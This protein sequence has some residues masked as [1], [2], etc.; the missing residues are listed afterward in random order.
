MRTGNPCGPDSV[1]CFHTF[2]WNVFALDT[3]YSFGSPWRSNKLYRNMDEDDSDDGFGPRS[4]VSFGGSS[5]CTVVNVEPVSVVSD[6]INSNLDQ[7]IREAQYRHCRRSFA[8]ANFLQGSAVRMPWEGASGM[9]LLNEMITNRLL[10][11]VPILPNVVEEVPAQTSLRISSQHLFPAVVKKLP[12]IKWPAQLV[13]KR[14][15]V[16]Q[17]WRIVI[18]ENYAATDLGLQLQD[19]ALELVTE[20]GLTRIVEDAFAAKPT[21]TLSKRVNPLLK[22]F[23]WTRKSYGIAGSPVIEK[24]AYEYVKQIIEMKAAP[25][26]P[27]AFLSALNFAA[28]FVR[29]QGALDA[30]SSLRIKGACHNHYLLKRMLKQS[31]LL[32]VAWVLIFEQGVFLCVDPVE[33]IVCGFVASLIHCRA[34]FS[35]L[36]MSVKIILDTN[37]EGEGFIEFSAVEIKTARTKESKKMFVPFVAPVQGVASKPWAKE[38][39]RQRTKQKIENFSCLLPSLSADGSW[40]DDPADSSTCS[41]WMQHI[42]IKFGVSPEDVE[43]TTSQ[44]CKATALSWCSK[45]NVPIETRQLLGHHVLSS[46]VTCFTYSR[47]AQSGPLR[48]YE[49]VLE[50]IRSRKFLPD[51]GRSGRFVKRRIDSAPFSVAEALGEDGTVEFECQINEESLNSPQF[52]VPDS[53]VHSE[54]IDHPI[55]AE[56]ESEE[57]QH[58]ASESSS[59]DSSSSGSEADAVEVFKLVKNKPAD[60]CPEGE[61]VKYVCRT[62]QLVHLKPVALGNK[63]RCSRI[64]SANFV[65]V[66]SEQAALLLGCAQCFHK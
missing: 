1:Q 11:N 25:T 10:V 60:I 54:P 2:S 6:S 45:F 65:L 58:S 8:F 47:D 52:P 41:K 51:L 4:V 42:L 14:H 57:S 21:S 12:L 40:L 64:I 48:A 3:S 9:G 55:A 19:A 16:L 18:E 50:N 56:A 5:Q 13:A 7:A 49:E 34:R 59:S 28:F 32:L 20:I 29:M 24:R 66:S 44:G 36:Q 33:K 35:D 38:W 17:K 53:P 62:S 37:E 30:A 63:F 61:F 31:K 23:V 39:M 43:G 22:F 15:L 26:A 27:S 46:Q